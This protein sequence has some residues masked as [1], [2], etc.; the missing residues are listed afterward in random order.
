MGNQSWST[1]NGSMVKSSSKSSQKNNSTEV[2]Y[3]FITQNISL[4]TVSIGA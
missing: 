4:F 3:A 2:N 1:L